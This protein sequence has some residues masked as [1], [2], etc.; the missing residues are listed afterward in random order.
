MKLGL[1]IGGA[2][3][4]L[5]LIVGMGCTVSYIGFRQDCVS[6][7][8]NISAQDKEM[9][10]VDTEITN[11]LQTQGLAVG[12]YKDLVVGA[13][14]AANTGRYGADGSKAMMQWIKEQNPTIDPSIFKK[15]MVCA[16]SGYAKFAAAQRKKIDLCRVYRKQLE[17]QQQVPIWGSIVTAGF[18]RKPWTE[19]ERVIVS[20]DTAKTWQSGIKQR[21]DP[22]KK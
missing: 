5:L 2:I 6:F 18:P 20:E 4:A 7:E 11:S 13:I 22:F 15:I 1:I 9:Q 12:E 3:G 19:L 21:I 16:E 8:N 14:K 17:Q 10:N